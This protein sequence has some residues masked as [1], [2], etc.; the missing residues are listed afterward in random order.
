MQNITLGIILLTL[1]VSCQTSA[2]IKRTLSK[3]E[4][5]KQMMATI[6]NDADMSKEMM[7]AMMNSE[8]GKM[9]MQEN[10]KMSMVMMENNS[11]MMKMMKEKPEMMK[12]MMKDMM[13]TCKTDSTMMATMCKTMMDDQGMM[14]KMEKM[15]EKKMKGMNH[16]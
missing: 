6:A 10:K 12:S 16:K 11:T 7:E 13:E 2:V 1:F 5:R 15:K 9:I 14:D 8:N 3:A 4:T